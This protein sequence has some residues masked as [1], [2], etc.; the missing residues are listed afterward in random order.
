M[1]AAD[2]EKQFDDHYGYGCPQPLQ[3]ILSFYEIS[4][5]V[6]FWTNVLL[7]LAD[8]IARGKQL[9]SG[10]FVW[11]RF[12]TN[13]N[14]LIETAARLIC[15]V[16]GP[17]R[18]KPLEELLDTENQKDLI[19]KIRWRQKRK[20]LKIKNEL[21]RP[22][23]I[24][25][26][27]LGSLI[28]GFMLKLFNDLLLIAFSDILADTLDF[29]LGTRSRYRQPDFGHRGEAAGSMPFTKS[30]TKDRSSLRRL[31]TAIL[32]EEASTSSPQLICQNCGHLV[33]MVINTDQN[34]LNEKEELFNTKQ[35]RARSLI[36][37]CNG[38]LKMRFRCLLKHRVLHYAPEKAT[39]IINACVVLHNMRIIYKESNPDPEVVNDGVEIDLGMYEHDNGMSQMINV[40]NDLNN[41]RRVRASVVQHFQH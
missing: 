24:L 23:W 36:E 6:V 1:L 39:A 4:K 18:E 29:I 8:A 41:G 26:I 22:L 10:N 5:I 20:A 40:N 37:R 21:H 14:K 19:D 30:R 38:L 35:M 7:I 16:F 11:L 34:P 33:T 25:T 31:N 9:L 28:Q 3:L 17:F 27:L 12:T 15:S 13:T 2:H 32:D